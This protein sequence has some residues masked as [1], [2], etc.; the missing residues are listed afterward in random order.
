LI[1]FIFIGTAFIAGKWIVQNWPDTPTEVASMDKSPVG[2]PPNQVPPTVVKPTF[3]PAPPTKTPE[4]TVA[5]AVVQ[6][7]TADILIPSPTATPKIW[8]VSFCAEPCNGKN[9]TYIFPERTTRIYMQWQYEN[10]P[11]NAHYVRSW[12]WEGN[13]WV[14]YDCNWDGPQT[15]EDSVILKEPQGLRSG[16]WEVTIAIEDDLVM[17][18]R[19]FIE[20]NWDYWAP[21]GVYYVCHK[22]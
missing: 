19:L 7:S 14:R 4:P 6:S 15:G 3:T 8:D 10:I 5:M 12:S 17:R 22:P 21:A 18:E 9:K 20:G 2:T 11:P 1:L 13:E 16:T